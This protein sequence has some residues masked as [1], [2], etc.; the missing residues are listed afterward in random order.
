MAGLCEWVLNSRK[1]PLSCENVDCRGPKIANSRST[2]Q[3][4]NSTGFYPRLQVDTTNSGAVGQA[5]GV[6]LTETI[7][8]AGLGPAMS[9]ALSGWRKPLAVHD[10]A[11]VVVDLAVTLALGGDC[12]ADIALLRSEPGLYGRVAS[13]ATPSRTIDAL[14]GDAPAALKAIDAARA[15][16]RSR[17]WGLAG[18]DSPDYAATAKNPLI[19]DLDATLVASHS[20]KELA[21]VTFKRGFGFHRLLSFI[22]HGTEGTGEP[23]AVMLRP[24]NAGSNTA[25]D[26]IVVIKGALAQL[27]GHR[28]RPGRAA[29]C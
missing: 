29:R 20:E 25:A 17:A 5:G 21:R 2:F 24:G 3:V 16:A 6:L 10:P 18:T 8:A 14:A 15:A 1:V 23:L 7:A 19:V 12:L 11:K 13:D 28:P 22:D 4:N 26:H 27:P 9:A